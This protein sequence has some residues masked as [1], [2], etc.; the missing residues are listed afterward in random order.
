MQVAVPD[1]SLVGD[2]IGEAPEI[3][4]PSA[5]HCNFKAF[6]L[7]EMHMQRRDRK[8]MMVV[9][10]VGQAPGE[11]TGLVVIDVGQ[12]CDSVSVRRNSLGLARAFPQQIANGLRS[13]AVALRRTAGV[14]EGE[15]VRVDADRD[16]FHG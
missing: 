9:L 13:A 6:V 16:A 12:G 15:K 3:A 10:A 14:N 5:Q 4:N 2:P 1:A 8:I 7:I 11:V